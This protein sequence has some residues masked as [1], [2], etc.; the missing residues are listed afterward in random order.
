MTTVREKII[1]DY[2]ERYN[3]FDIESMVK[4]FHN[5]IVFENISNG[6]VNLSIKG[7]EAFITQAKLAAACFSERNQVMKSIKFHDNEFTVEIDYSAILAMDLPNGL[8]KGEEL[9]LSGKSVF[10]FINN[11]IIALTDSS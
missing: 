4:H 11:K 8:K 5:E 2:I 6:E 10:R 1:R 3:Q 9:K 7:K